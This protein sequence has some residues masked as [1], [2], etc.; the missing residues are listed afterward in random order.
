MCWVTLGSDWKAEAK[1]TAQ[2]DSLLLLVSS[3]GSAEEASYLLRNRSYKRGISCVKA[4][5]KP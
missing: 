2:L 5:S 4:F 1:L 3:G